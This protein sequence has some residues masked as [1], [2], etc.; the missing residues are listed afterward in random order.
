MYVLSNLKLKLIQKKVT[1]NRMTSL[2]NDTIS[3]SVKR[4]LAYRNHLSTEANSTISK[5]CLDHIC[6]SCLLLIY[7]FVHLL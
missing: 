3:Q 2:K 5:R 7:L 4:R 1:Q 6:C